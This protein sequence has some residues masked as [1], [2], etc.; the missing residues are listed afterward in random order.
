MLFFRMALGS[1]EFYSTTRPYSR[2]L[3][4]TLAPFSQS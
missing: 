3:C 1:F 2:V 4:F